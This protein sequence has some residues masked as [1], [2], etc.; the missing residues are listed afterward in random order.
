[1][2]GAHSVKRTDRPRAARKGRGKVVAIVICVILVLALAGG[3]I[4]LFA[5]GKV[6]LPGFASQQASSPA[7][8]SSSNASS[9]S[10]ESSQGSDASGSA[11][12]TESGSSSAATVPASQVYTNA[13]FGYQ[14]DVPEGFV[15]GSEVDNGAGVILTNSKL[16]MTANV[17]G[18]NNVD[19]LDAD[20]IMNSLWNGSE[21]SI[22]R[23]EGNRVIIYQYDDEYEYFYWVNI[24]PGSINQMEIRYPLQD[25]NRDELDAAQSLMQGFIPGDLNI[26]H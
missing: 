4:F 23:A 21:D 1:M 10:S 11:E 5:T 13:V 16:R 3:V 19:N 24:G 6:E 20:A 18:Y 26:A 15:L 9:P 25:D 12:A 14:L 22:A 17:T 7:S 2:K 8:S